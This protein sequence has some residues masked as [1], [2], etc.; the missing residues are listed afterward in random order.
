[1]KC[2]KRWIMHKQSNRCEICNAVFDISEDRTSVKQM[3]R[4]F[5]CH[6]CCGLIVK[7]LLFS[8]SLMPLAN[9]ILQQVSERDMDL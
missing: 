9:I 3:V 4:T 2:L 8:A 7:H 5:C 1:M 6:R